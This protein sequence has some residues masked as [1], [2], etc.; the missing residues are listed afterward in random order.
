MEITVTVEYF[1][2]FGKQITTETCVVRKVLFW[3]LVWGMNGILSSQGTVGSDG[4]EVPETSV[5][6]CRYAKTEKIQKTHSW[7]AFALRNL[8]R[9]TPHSSE[10]C[11]V[12]QDTF[13]LVAN[14]WMLTTSSTLCLKSHF[15]LALWPW[16]FFLYLL[17]YFEYWF[18][19]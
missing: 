17:V 15:S 4:A 14:K 10:N 11:Y 6:C 18:G 16:Y 1:L 8:S 5:L 9:F 3:N 2:C 19:Y 12:D 7:K 13:C